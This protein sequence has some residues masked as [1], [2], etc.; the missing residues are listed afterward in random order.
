MYGNYLT[1]R[2][3]FNTFFTLYK[4]P[5]IDVFKSRDE[6]KGGNGPRWPSSEGAKCLGT[7]V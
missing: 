1:S 6:F 2:V 7:P 3:R 5:I 4:H